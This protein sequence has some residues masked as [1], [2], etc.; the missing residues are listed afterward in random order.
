M[1]IGASLWLGLQGSK[2]KY[3]ELRPA[4]TQEQG[5]AMTDLLMMSSTA[6]TRAA[7]E[8]QKQFDAQMNDIAPRTLPR[9]DRADSSMRILAKE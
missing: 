8:N 4:A 3:A 6:L 9:F 5:G 2:T 1:A 7:L